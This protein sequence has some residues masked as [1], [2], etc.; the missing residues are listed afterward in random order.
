MVI[1]YELSDR[2]Y[3]TSAM[4]ETSVY[5]FIEMLW[6]KLHPPAMQPEPSPS[7]ECPGC[8]RYVLAHLVDQHVYRCI[9]PLR[10][11]RLRR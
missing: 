1:Q 2:H 7:V 3:L 4:D 10:R 8:G 11:N 5:N 9:P 6:D